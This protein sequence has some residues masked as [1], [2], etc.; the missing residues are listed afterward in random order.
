MVGNG[1]LKG[2]HMSISP[3]PESVRIVNIADGAQVFDGK[4]FVGEVHKHNN[5]GVQWLSRPAGDR[6]E[7]NRW[8]KSKTEAVRYLLTLSRPTPAVSYPPVSA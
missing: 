8:H 1:H 4:Q 5:W 3:Y 2:E 6:L 7:L